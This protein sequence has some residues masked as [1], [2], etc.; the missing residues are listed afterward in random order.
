MSWSEDG[1][2]FI[3]KD[4][5]TLTSQILPKHFKH[6]NFASFVRQLNMYGFHKIRS[7]SDGHIF[8]HEYFKKDDVYLIF[9]LANYYLKLNVER[10]VVQPVIT[11]MQANLKS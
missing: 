2:S 1:K 10:L 9:Y 6:N 8:E 3:I 5:A 4:I 11:K 7:N